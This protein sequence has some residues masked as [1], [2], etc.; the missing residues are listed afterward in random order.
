M[1]VRCFCPALHESLWLNGLEEFADGR[2]DGLLSLYQIRN[3][4]FVNASSVMLDER[5]KSRGCGEKPDHQETRA[6]QLPCIA[7]FV[8]FAPC[9]SEQHHQR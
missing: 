9:A 4:F 7:L 8:R 3:C 2:I 5:L 1:Q 6:P